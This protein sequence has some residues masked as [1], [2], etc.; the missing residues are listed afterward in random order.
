M[1]VSKSGFGYF[2]T[3]YYNIDQKIKTLSFEIQALTATQW[4]KKYITD[5]LNSIKTKN[6][7]IISFYEQLNTN[8]PNKTNKTQPT[9]DGMFSANVLLYGILLMCLLILLLHFLI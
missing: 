5:T 7:N 2:L 6:I 4:S 9:N 8:K 3:R 1:S